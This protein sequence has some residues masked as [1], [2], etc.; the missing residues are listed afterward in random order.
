MFTSPLGPMVVLQSVTPL[1][2]LLQ[3]VIHRVYTPTLNAPLGAALVVLEAYQFQRDVAIWNSK[4]Y[5]NSPTYVKSD[6]TIR[7]FRTWFSQ[8]YSKNSIPLR[9]AMQ[10]PLD[11]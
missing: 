5:V 9:D 10:N 1:G 6:K 11:W 8:F 4:R 2:P 7:A 3:R